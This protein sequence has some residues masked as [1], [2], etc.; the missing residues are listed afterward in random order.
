MDVSKLDECSEEDNHW[1]VVEED[2]L[3]VDEV[4]VQWVFWLL[5]DS[6]EK[7]SVHAIL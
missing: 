5:I 2:H 7:V 6:E 3:V 1:E 4:V